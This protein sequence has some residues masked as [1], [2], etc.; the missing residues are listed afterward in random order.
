VPPLLSL[1]G[2]PA[3]SASL[4]HRSLSLS[5]CCGPHHVNTR[6]PCARTSPL[7]PQPHSPARPLQM[8]ARARRGSHTHVACQGL[9]PPTSSHLNPS[10]AP[11]TLPSLIHMPAEP[12]PHPRTAR[13]LGRNCRR[14]APILLVTLMPHRAL[15]H[16]ELPLGASRSELAPNSPFSLWFALPVHNYRSRC[17]RRHSKPLLSR[18]SRREVPKV[19]NLPCPSSSLPRSLLHVIA[20]QSSQRRRRAASSWTSALW[21]PYCGL[22]STI[23]FPAPPIFP[24]HPSRHKTPRATAPLVS[25]ELLT[26]DVGGVASSGKRK[27]AEGGR[28]ILT[29]HPKSNSLIL[30]NLSQILTVRPRSEGT[31]TTPA[32]MSL[33]L[34]PTCQSSEPRAAPLAEASI[35][36]P[37]KPSVAH[38]AEARIC[39]P[40]EP[41][42]VPLAEAR[43]PSSD[44]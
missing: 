41:H 34:G 19:R 40:S 9:N 18:C 28:P 20:R 30:I 14:S 1:P 7:T 8:P 44:A 3:L 33:P 31:T 11:L 27:R 35:R 36:Q 17:R 23:G 29:V 2:G 37:S 39:K 15:C 24:G 4:R 16:G 12:R 38:S 22:A 6:C 13:M 43:V 32:P 25:S 26:A 21:C 42:V 10:G 5:L